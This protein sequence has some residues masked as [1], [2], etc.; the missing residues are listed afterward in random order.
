MNKIILWGIFIL[1]LSIIG[2]YIGHALV[3]RDLRLVSV[4]NGKLITENYELRKAH[5]K[6]WSER[7]DLWLEI[8][9]LKRINQK[10]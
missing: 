3:D 1:S 4:D 7:S 6:L 10:G 8:G 5:G 2:S 9:R